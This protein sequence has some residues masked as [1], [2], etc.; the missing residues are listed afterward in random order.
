MKRFLLAGAAAVA[1]WGAP[2]IAADMPTKAVPAPVFDW[3]GFY[4]GGNIGDAFRGHVNF[5]DPDED[6]ANFKFKTNSGFLAGAQAGYN[7]RTGNLLYGLEGDLGYMGIRKTFVVPTDP[8]IND[9]FK[10]GMYGDITARLGIVFDRLLVY[11]KGGAAF[12]HDSR[13]N[14]IGETTANTG[15]LTGWAAGGGFEYEI[16]PRWSFKAEYMYFDVSGR[17]V[18][19]SDGDR[20]RNQLT[21]QTVKI[22]L[23]YFF[24]K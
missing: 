3:T 19:P 21:A 18:F 1:L 7:W 6:G 16:A 22:G 24:G 20:F 15:A 10:A 17:T 5:D 8:V 4:L 12:F 2:A 13:V 9:V 14:D 23:N 11:G